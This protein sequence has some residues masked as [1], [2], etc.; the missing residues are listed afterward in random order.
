ME[1]F[2][3]ELSSRPLADNNDDAR[4]RVLGLL[5]TMKSLRDYDINIMRTHDG[6]F[7]EQISHDYTFGSFFCDTSVNN[8]LQL[9][10]RTI[11]A[12]PFIEDDNSDE[13]EQFVVNSFTAK[14]HENQDVTPEGL[15]SAHIFNSPAISLNSH[16]HWR[17][18]LLNIAILDDEQNTTQTEVLNLYSKECV[19]KD[20]FQ[21]WLNYLNPPIEL[22]SEQN[23]YK[24][25]LPAQFRFEKKAIQ[26]IISW[27]YNDKRFL[28]RVVELI[29]DIPQNPFKGGKGKTETLGSTSGK[30][31]KRI[32]RK[33]RII[34]TYTE[35]IIVIHQCRGHYSDK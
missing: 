13:V 22:N 28:N 25:F 26:D 27:F 29:K 10:L 24:V 17:N 31:S 21:N 7:A 11:V 30:A 12:N 8:N 18:S 33:D 32:A 23:I 35:K 16:S 2:Y 15:A 6:F 5:D 19:N 14:N 3:N 9:L 20:G 1:V 4:S 34:Y